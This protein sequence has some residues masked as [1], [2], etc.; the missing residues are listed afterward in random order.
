MKLEEAIKHLEESLNNPEHKWSCEECKA[1]HEQLLM[2]LKDYKRLLE[3]PKG[4]LISREVINSEIEKRYCNK[5][6]VV[7]SEEPYCPDSCPARFLKN[8]VKDCPTVPDRPQGEWIEVG[9]NQPYSKDKLYGCSKCRFGGYL[10]SD[11]KNVN[12]C[13]N[14]GA[15]MNY[16]SKS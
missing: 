12:F 10:L 4:D 14:C 16:Q 6:C 13:P 5:H 9:D 7:P 3:M 2:W 8:I 15:R 1:E 11:T